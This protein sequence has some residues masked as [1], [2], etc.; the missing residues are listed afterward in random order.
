MGSG[1]KAGGAGTTYDYY[2]TLAGAVCIGPAE[3]LV[4]III[5]GQEVWPKGTAWVLGGLCT[6]NTLYVFDAQTWE[7]TNTHVATAANAPGTDASTPGWVNEGW[8]EY[9]YARSA[10]L[11]DNFSLTGSDG[12]AYGV[13]TFYWGTLAQT[14]DALMAATGNDGGVKGNLGQGDQHPDYE[15]LVYVVVRDFLLGQ[16]VQSGPNLEIVVRRAPNQALVTG[17][18]A[19]ITDGQAN[20]AAV[21]AEILTDENCLALPAAQVD[22]V[23]LQAVADYLQANQTMFGASVLL[24]AMTTVAAFFDDLVQMFDGYVRFNPTTQKIEVGV[25]QHGLIPAAGS[26]VTLTADSF[27][28]IP[29]FN[30]KSWQQTISRATVRY[31]SRQINYQ[32]TSVQVDD[33]RAFFVL[34]TVRE[35]AVDRPWIARQAQA[36]LHGRETLRVIGHAQM[37]G[38]LEVRREIGRS[39]RAG[40]YVLVDVDLEPDAN[41]LYQFF[42]VT[43]RKIPPTGPITLS[44]F[45]DNTLAPVPWNGSTAP[46][47]VSEPVV[48][49]VTNWRVIE[50]PFL[51]S[52]EVGAIVV[53]AQRPNNLITSMAIYLD[54]NP[55]GTFSLLGIQ[56]N[57]AAQATLLQAVAVGDTTLQLAVD[58]T[59][60]D[61][62]YLTQQYS[63]NDAVNDVM[64]AILVD[65]SGAAAAG[66]QV[67]ESGGYGILEICSVSV[68]ALVNPPLAGAG[69]DTIGG[70]GGDTVAG[71]AD[72]NTGYY[73]LTVLRG[74]KNT[75]PT[76]FATAT[77]EV[78]LVPAALLSFFTANIF[79]QIR[80]NRLLGLT[81]N[82]IQLRFCPATF[83]DALALSAATSE[84]FQFPLNSA[85][86]PSLTLTKPAT[87]AQNLISATLPVTLKVAG[88]WATQDNALVKIQVLI[89]LATDTADRV[90]ISENFAG[91]G[92][93]TFA[94]AVQFDHAGSW[95]VKLIAQEATGIIV[96]RDIAVTVTS[97]GGI[98]CALPQ[99]F[100]VN[101]N[102]VTDVSGAP[103]TEPSQSG[104]YVT[105]GSFIPYGA[106]ALQCTTP[107]ATIFFQTNGPVL[108]AGQLGASAATQTYA[109]GYNQP[110]LMPVDSATVI[111]NSNNMDWLFVEVWVTAPGYTKSDTLTFS[112]PLAYSPT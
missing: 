89:R 97:T 27:T 53:L 59:Q 2:G 112:L 58:L 77:T 50:A 56:N 86:V 44:V 35:Q 31:N 19:G 104:W 64:L 40:D 47:T 8:L 48:P 106:L 5:D 37:T 78:W 57:F 92:K 1:G 9:T 33:P 100:D 76:A 98:K 110:F 109:L 93:K 69:G 15:G 3:N 55:A 20:L 49:P 111:S 83:V 72:S 34:G 91:T 108:L 66:G 43:Q 82:E 28:K 17:A 73:N 68:S 61:A 65:V 4:A 32:Q 95:T 7:C 84:A 52:G 54:T 102:E 96:E 60:V 18:A 87:F 24:D 62:D 41:T 21:M 42:R 90:V 67:V 14:V 81:P 70:V 16:E 6:A 94:T 10:E 63:A 45:A 103:V 101:G 29:T 12:T 11:F 105:P 23:S 74:R 99:M 46:V 13:L 22:T 107:G 38:E 51:L 36:I 25:Y 26:Y 75:A 80:A 79:D 39:I 71:V 88:F 30:V 85:S